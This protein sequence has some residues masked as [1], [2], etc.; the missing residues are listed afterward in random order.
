MARD[1]YGLADGVNGQVEN[2]SYC[3]KKS[4]EARNVDS[5]SEAMGYHN[6]SD[7]ANNAKAPVPMKAD[8]QNLQLGPEA[9]DSRYDYDSMARS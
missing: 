8:K 4:F 1:S 3:M 7:L 5:M 6:M 2:E 9:S